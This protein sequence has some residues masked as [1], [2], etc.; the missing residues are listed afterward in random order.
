[1]SDEAETMRPQVVASLSA[2]TSTGQRPLIH[3][4]VLDGDGPEGPGYALGLCRPERVQ[5][6]SVGRLDLQT[7]THERLLLA[8]LSA[9]AMAHVR[10]SQLQIGDAVLVLGGDPWSLLLLQWARLQ[11]AS[12]LVMVRS[13]SRSAGAQ[14]AAS[15]VDLE[16][17][18]PTA[19]D[20]ARAVKLTP[21]GVGFDVVF[22]A[23]GSEESMTRLLAVLRDGGRY[24]LTGFDVQQHVALNAYPDLHRRDLEVLSVSDRTPVEGFAGLFRFALQMI[25]LGRLPVDA[26]VDQ[27]S[28]WRVSLQ[29]GLK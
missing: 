26:V 29:S 13:G 24:L 18:N 27:A 28:G 8:G 17:T 4:G 12:P 25:D 10:E 2:D 21:G 6:H 20:M 7:V 22:D 16:L 5:W 14:A 15:G 11:G 23:T 19:A 9:V 3:L 1:M